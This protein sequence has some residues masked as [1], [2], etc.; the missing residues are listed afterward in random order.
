MKHF[1]RG[2]ATKFCCI[3]L[4]TF[5]LCLS[6]CFKVPNFSKGYGYEINLMPIAIAYYLE[7]DRFQYKEDVE[8]HVSYGH[9]PGFDRVPDEKSSLPFCLF[10]N[11][12]NDGPINEEDYKQYNGFELLE[13][14]STKNFY[15][16]DYMYYQ[17]GYDSKRFNH[18]VTCTIPYEYFDRLWAKGPYKSSFKLFAGQL[19]KDENEQIQV[20][21]ISYD[22]IELHF[23]IN[24][25]TK[26]IKIIL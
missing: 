18:T 8:I 22:E 3:P 2:K 25:D 11:Y 5:G 21:G 15:T 9:G 7:K 26:N 20:Y 17:N 13:E 6:S 4:A 16:D 23:S 14:V 19:Y 1:R 12:W 10:L 24:P